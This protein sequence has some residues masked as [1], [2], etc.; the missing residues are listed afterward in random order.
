MDCSSLPEGCSTGISLRHSIHVDLSE[1][2]KRLSERATRRDIVNSALLDYYRCPETLGDFTL[3]GTPS[4]N[5]GYFQ[6]G[7]DAICYGQCSGDSIAPRATDELYDALRDVVANGDTLRLPFDPSEIVTNLR[8]ERYASLETVAGATRYGRLALQKIYYSLRPFLTVPVRKYLQRIQLR[9]WV[10]IP[11]P[12]WPVD[13]TV[14][15]ILERL[16]TLLLKAGV[17]EKIP[18]IWFWPK[19]F[20]TCAIVTHDVETVAGRNFCP[21]LMNLDDSYGMKSSFQIVPEDRYA[22]SQSLLDEIRH[23]GFEI[24]VHD[25]NH[26]GR[27]FSSREQFLLRAKRINRYGREYG[28]SGFRSAVLYHNLNWYDSLD[29]SY[30]MSVPSVGH[31]EAQRG[32][33]CSA[34]PFFIGNILELPVTTTQDYSLFH[35]LNQYSTDLW[36]R[37]VSGIMEKH[38]LC[39]FIVHPDYL[40]EERAQYT[41]KSLLSYLGD[42]RSEGKLW[43]ALPREVNQWWRARSQMK[44]VCQGNNWVIEGSESDRARIAY[45]VL[46]GDRLVYVLGPEDECWNGQ[47]SS[48]VISQPSALVETC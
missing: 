48:R 20:P 31:L 5:S 27:L 43:L 33:C 3:T 11:F 1:T 7:P 26:D 16:L 8:Y 24:N 45:A 12:S 40:I 30:D 32:G 47:T 9:D 41:Y 18:F 36:R 22:V 21:D 17:I 46:E 44:L 34:M 4:A 14:E 13:L 25:L 39:S 38:G 10:G 28:A 42:L 35:I 6:F 29:F 23:R 19:G 37:Q 2:E 15:R